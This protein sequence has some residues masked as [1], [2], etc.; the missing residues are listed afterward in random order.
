M[1][2]GGRDAQDADL[3]EIHYNIDRY[4]TSSRQLHTRH[5]IHNT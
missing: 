5:T 3:S 2:N 1:N 4:Y